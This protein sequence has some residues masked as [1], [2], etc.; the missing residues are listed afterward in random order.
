MAEFEQ[1]VGPL[2]DLSELLYVAALQQASLN[3]RKDT[4]ITPA[5]I[6]LFLISRYG[7]KINPEDV[8][9]CILNDISGDSNT[10]DLVEMVAL[11]FIPQLLKMKESEQD[12]SKLVPVGR[13][14]LSFVLDSIK[15]DMLA[16][17]NSK[18]GERQDVGAE[19]STSLIREM[20][21]RYGE[22]ALAAD[23][24]LIDEMLLMARNGKGPDEKVHFDFDTFLGA[25][26]HDIGLFDTQRESRFS[27]NWNDVF[28]EDSPAI[29][30]ATVEGNGCKKKYSIHSTAGPIDM[31]A[32]TYFCRIQM[33]INWLF[34]VF[35]YFAY[36][37]TEVPT[38]SQN[39]PEFMV[40]STWIDNQQMAGCSIGLSIVDWLIS[41]ALGTTRLD[42]IGYEVL[43]RKEKK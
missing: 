33:L 20:F 22:T 24:R 19:L 9:E 8:Q 17:Q 25:L 6:S 11:L 18:D 1:P 34:F 4:T 32:H 42:M 15:H 40:L 23:D 3:L 21:L 31:V 12:I 7:L 37:Y 43:R 39:C 5:D 14:P 28:G 30:G 2:A 13:D 36:L 35:T 27:T 41:L 29:D 38:F 16:G 26:T 10:M